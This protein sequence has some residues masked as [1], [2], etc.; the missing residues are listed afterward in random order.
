M[1]LTMLSICN[2]W[3]TG[4]IVAHIDKAWGAK[5]HPNTFQEWQ[6][7]VLLYQLRIACSLSDTRLVSINLVFIPVTVFFFLL[8]PNGQISWQSITVCLC[9]SHLHR[10]KHSKKASIKHQSNQTKKPL[11]LYNWCFPG[12]FL[13]IFLRVVSPWKLDKNKRVAS[14]IS[15][16]H[17]LFSSLFRRVKSRNLEEYRREGIW[18][19][20]QWNLCWHWK[21]FGSYLSF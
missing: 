7:T 13:V 3:F 19:T 8:D 10:Q 18:Q 1:V 21:Q 12:S 15:Y 20:N 4:I 2:S 6:L 9:F 11:A 16:Q 5:R 17:D 14:F